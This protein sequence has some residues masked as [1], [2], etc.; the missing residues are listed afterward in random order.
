MP[1]A[2]VTY[3]VEDGRAVSLSVRI[4]DGQA[5]GSAA[6]LGTH[7]VAEGPEIEDHELGEGGHLRGRVLVVSTTV[8]DIRAEHD[9]TSAFVELR[10]GHP[11]TMP[12]IQAQTAPTGGAVNYLTVVRFI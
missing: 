2:S 5:G 4:G 6:F 12:V 1:T 10:G 11:E 9:R 7:K 8:V 3:I